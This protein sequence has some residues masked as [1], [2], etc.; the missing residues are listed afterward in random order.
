MIPDKER[1]IVKGEKEPTKITVI[2]NHQHLPKCRGYGSR[3]HG[4]EKTLR[5]ALS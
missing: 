4:S 5:A 1:R 2:D 3:I